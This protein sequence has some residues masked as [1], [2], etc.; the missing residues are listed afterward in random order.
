MT[1]KSTI[2]TTIYH[3]PRCSKSRQTYAILETEGVNINEIRYLE[4][5]PSTQELDALCLAMGVEPLEIIRTKESLFKEL[6]LSKSDIKPR[7]AWLDIMVANPRLI[8]RP[9][10]KIGDQV[11]IGRPPEKVLDI[12]K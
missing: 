8:E 5:P 11:V 4:T 7:Q 6:G 3:N 12:L 1:S 9:I 2:Q 10:V